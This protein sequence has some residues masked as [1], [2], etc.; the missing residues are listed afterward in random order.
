MLA[1]ANNIPMV[2]V[3]H[4]E[5]HLFAG[6]VEHPGLR[7]PFLGLVVSGGHT[8]LVIF[9]GYGRYQKL[10]STRDDAAGEAFDKVANLLNLPFPGGP[11]IDQAARKGNPASIAFPRAWIPGTHDF[12]FS[13]LKTSVANY[14]R[15]TPFRQRPTVADL[16]ASFQESVVDVLVKKTMRA[17]ES[18]RLSSIVV[19]G[20]VAANHRLRSAFQQAARTNK[21]RVYLPS[22][23]F[24]TDNAAM[25]AAAGYYKLKRGLH[26]RERLMVNANLEVSNW[27]AR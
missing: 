22:L 12:S 16:A 4:L 20:G 10:G 26:R 3:N 25:I 15:E 1:W 17:A 6:L 18:H 24:C 5:G 8:E 11:S 23:S 19:G 7:P 27:P 13:G 21:V 9:K 14:L 2:G